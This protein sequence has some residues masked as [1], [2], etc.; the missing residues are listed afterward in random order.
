MRHPVPS[1]LL[2][3]P[4]AFVV[5]R[6]LAIVTKQSKNFFDRPAAP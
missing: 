5:I 6:R 1:R 3:N 4:P 2:D